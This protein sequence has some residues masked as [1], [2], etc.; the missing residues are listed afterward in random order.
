MKVVGRH[1]WILNCLITES[2]ETRN[3]EIVMRFTATICG[4][5]NFKLY[6]GS[7]HTVNLTKKVC[8]K[9]AEIRDRIVAG[10]ETVFKKGGYELVS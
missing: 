10:D 8:L 5:R 6:E 3:G 1:K 7:P 4:W 2:H 9:A